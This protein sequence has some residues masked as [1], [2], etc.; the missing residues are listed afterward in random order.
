[1]PPRITGSLPPTV[2]ISDLRHPAPVAKDAAGFVSYVHPGDVSLLAD[3]R[4]PASIPTGT[5][6]PLVANVQWL[7]CSENMCVPERTQ[8]TL[9]LVVGT[10]I[11]SRSSKDF[12]FIEQSLR[13]EEHT[14]EL[15]SLMRISYA[16]SRLKT[17]NTST[18]ST[19]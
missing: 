6:L 2:K 15:Q 19:P 4:I 18:H 17:T 14:S 9:A 10:G 13:S 7:T 12:D 11:G 1:M 16:V 8:L 3:L 5:T